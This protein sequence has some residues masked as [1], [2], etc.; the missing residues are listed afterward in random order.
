MLFAFIVWS[1][2]C[3]LPAILNIE[4]YR[5]KDVFESNLILFVINKNN[6]PTYKE[7]ERIANMFLF[8]KLNF[9]KFK[10]LTLQ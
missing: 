1:Y 3:V 9:F 7:H 8:F 10:L 4:L 6:L 5:K 2:K